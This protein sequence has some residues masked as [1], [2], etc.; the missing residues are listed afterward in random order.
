MVPT[1]ACQR[2]RPSSSDSARSR[3]PRSR[4]TAA[5]TVS[6]AAVRVPGR[7]EYGNTCTFEI[8]SRSTS[9]RVRANASSS[10]AGN[11]TITSV[12]RLRCARGARRR[13]NCVAV[14]RRPIARS[15]ASSPDCSG[16]W[17]CGETVG[18]SHQGVDQLVVDVIDLDRREPEP[19]EPWQRAGLAHEA[20]ECE[21][22]GTVAEAAEVDT[23]E[24]DLSVSLR[25]PAPDLA[26]HCVHGS[27]PRLASYERDHAERAGERAA[28]LDP[29]KG[30]N[31]VEPMLGV[32]AADR[33]D[34]ARDE[35][36][37]VVS[38]ATGD[39]DVGSCTVER[40][41]EPRRAARDVDGAR[42]AC[43]ARRGLA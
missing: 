43:C 30:A 7:G 18:V 6:A 31:P 29:H 16:T 14:Y 20:R 24:D 39:D 12:V 27:A 15:T 22:G 34:I 17:R 37:R 36:G 28:V 11:P 1:L 3:A 40:P 5:G 19:L 8:P 23:R 26:E 9:S 10:S 41:L 38:R 42:T 21:A 33:A 2:R 13:A 4:F 25:D 35:S 32:D